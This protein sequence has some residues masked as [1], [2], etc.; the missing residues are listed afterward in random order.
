MLTLRK[1][2]NRWQLIRWTRLDDGGERGTPIESFDD[3]DLAVAQLKRRG[4][5]FEVE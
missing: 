2:N 1:C 4:V 3:F 5:D